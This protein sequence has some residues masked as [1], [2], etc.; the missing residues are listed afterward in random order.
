MIPGNINTDLISGADD[1]GYA[2][3][4]S[5]RFNSSDSG[6]CARTM[7]SAS[8]TY[9]LSMWVKR[10]TITSNYKYLFSSGNA[11]I[12]FYTGTDQFYI[13]D[14]STVHATTGVY[15]DTSAWYHILLSVSSNTGAAYINGTQVLSGKSTASL[16]TATNAT[17]IGRYYNSGSGDFYFDGYIADVYLIDGQALTPSS[18]TEVSATTGQLI[19]KAYTGSFGTNGFWLKFSDNSNNTATTLGKDY[20]GNSNNWSPTNLSV[21]NESTEQPR[22]YSSSTLYSTK[23]A[24][25]ANATPRGVGSFTTTSGG[26]YVYLVLNGGGTPGTNNVFTSNFG[27]SFN[28]YGNVGG[29]YTRDGS[30]TSSEAP[31]I[32][33]TNGSFTPANYQVSNTQDFYAFA[34]SNNGGQPGNTFSSITIT[35]LTTASFKNT[36]AQIGAGNDSLVDTPTSGS[37]VDTGLGGQVTGNYAT[38]NPLLM[39]PLYMTSRNGNLDAVP[40]GSDYNGAALNIPIEV[41][42]S[43]KWYVEFSNSN[44]NTTSYTG[45]GLVANQTTPFSQNTNI[46][47]VYLANGQKKISGNSSA[48]GSAHSSNDIIG[49]AVDEASGV[50]TCYRNGSSQGTL[51]TLPVGLYQFMGI[52]YGTTSTMTVNSGQRPF[53][54]TAPS[55]FKALCD[56]N[57]PAPTIAKGS[58]AMDV[59]LYTGNGS[60]QTISGLGFSPDLVWIKA[61]NTTNAHQIFDTV[62]G[63]SIGLSSNTADADSNNA[64]YGLTSFG[65]SSFNVN[66]ISNGGYGVNGSSL[67]QVYAAWCWDAGS[68]TV[69]NT[70]GSITSSVR[71]NPSAGFSIV[72]YTGTGANAT[73]GH[74]LGVAPGLVIVKSR[75]ANFVNWGVWHSTFA[76]NE[77]I[78]LSTIG[79]KTTDATMWNSTSPSSS[80]FS[81]GTNATVNQS[82]FN[83]V[84]YCFAPVA[85]YSSGFSYTGNGSTDGSFVYLGFRPRLILLK[86]SSTTGNWTL[87]DTAREGY[88]VDNNPLYPNLGDAEGTTD[89]LDITSN[90][91]KLRT[92]DVSVNSSGATYVG[93]AWAEAPFAYSRAR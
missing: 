62:R 92:T 9:T 87:L 47:Y 40:A 66:D 75:G 78:L 19:P 48:Y 14:G 7:S 28:M 80:V 1:T 31:L 64:P 6:F 22:W 54:Y 69:T 5:L 49:I 24:V 74:G 58:A 53:A 86:C 3:S 37:Q 50:V 10:S 52:G 12:A 4:R 56:T 90:G 42:K 23:A 29:A 93:Y 59:K 68:T 91:F 34:A 25:V 71:A 32:G 38:W 36:S 44:V 83:Y 30:Y 45:F 18:F 84:A 79:G 33:W 46:G 8:S 61:R 43:S 89:L 88:N 11:G 67:S 27:S 16:S 72:T 85:G 81:L 60:T 15:R 57:L 63:A 51:A 73:V 13:F 35:A 70:Q 21:G 76:G 2:I 55:G 26:E 65:A 39:N 20:S 77:Y 17:N 82:T 41:G